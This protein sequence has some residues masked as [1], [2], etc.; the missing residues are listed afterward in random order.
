MVKK[1]TK[2]YI[3]NNKTYFLIKICSLLKV[4]SFFFKLNTSKIYYILKEIYNLSYIIII[5]II[6]NMK[7]FILFYYIMDYFKMI[8]NKNIIKIIKKKYAK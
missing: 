1:E 3:G 5:I 2:T 7:Y 4:L 6:L 8:T